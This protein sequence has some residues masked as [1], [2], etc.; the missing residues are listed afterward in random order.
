[1][2]PRPSTFSIVARDPEQ[3]AVGVAVQSKFVSVGSVVPFAA[4]DA[5]AIATQ[6]FANVAYGPKGLDLLRDGYE[7]D[8]V[9]ERLTQADE[10]APSR[11]L[12]I[13]G[14]DGSVAAFT[15]DECL[16]HASDRQGENYTVQGNI[17]EGRETVD[18]MAEA[19]ESTDGG[20]PERLLAALFAGNDAGGDTRG[21][22]SAAMYVAKP[23]GGYDGR[24]DRW[25]DVRVDD[26]EHPIEELERVFRIYDVTL[27]ERESPPSVT[28]LQGE[29][30]TAVLDVLANLGVYD[31]DPGGEMGEAEREALETFRGMWNFENHSLEVLEDAIARGWA[32]AAGSGEAKLVNAIWHG[33]SRLDRK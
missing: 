21:E 29:T 18:A 22:Q 20:L 30:A 24:N 9:I 28:T 27:L 26:H 7:A 23:E 3:D 2:Q 11:Q 10:D 33:I 17:L 14:R 12:G 31:G 25:I 13:V 8:T 15:G 16:D 4:A 32:D 1:M 5:G 6:S 19:F